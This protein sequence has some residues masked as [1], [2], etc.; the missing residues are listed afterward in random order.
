MAILKNEKNKPHIIISA[1]GHTNHGKT[2]LTAAI[3]KVLKFLGNAEYRT[4][5]QLNRERGIENFIVPIEYETDTRKYSHI[6]Y[7]DHSE[8]MNNLIKGTLQI[9]GAILVVSATD[10]VMPQTTEIITLAR[11]IGI[12]HLAVFLNK[13]DLSDDEELLE[14]VEMEIRELLSFN[15][16]DG[17]NIPIVKGSALDILESNSTNVNAPVY[18]PI[19]EL[20]KN[21]EK[22]IPTPQRSF[23]YEYTEE[24]VGELLNGIRKINLN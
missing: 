18:G 20:M 17:D 9:D 21:V 10:G 4:Y 6:D 13:C 1:I 16:Y 15:G 14:L 2:A 11:K 7:R 5:D 22:Y 3:T 23:E 24:R 19:I 8:F 12:L